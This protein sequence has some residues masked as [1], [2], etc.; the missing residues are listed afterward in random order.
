LVVIRNV[1]LYIDFVS[2]GSCSLNGVAKNELFSN[3]QKLVELMLLAQTM[4]SE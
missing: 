4:T 3:I 1:P 2:C